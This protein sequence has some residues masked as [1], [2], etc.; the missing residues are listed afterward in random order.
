MKCDDG[1]A[2][3]GDGC[4]TNCTISGCGNGILT[5][6]EFCDDGNLQDGDGCDSNCT[7]TACGNGIQ[8]AGEACDDG[9]DVDR[10]ECRLGCTLNAVPVVTDVIIQPA[11]VVFVGTELTCTADVTDANDDPD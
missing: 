10:D 7:P 1:N 2:V 6:D 11:D 9:N 8:T 3:D 5:G 4:D